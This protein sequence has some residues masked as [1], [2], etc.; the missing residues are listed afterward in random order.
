MATTEY[1]TA[2]AERVQLWAKKIWLEMPREIFWGKFMK[3][4]DLNSPIEVKRDLEG[5]PG[6]RL[7]FYLAN[8]LDGAGVAGDNILED[9][10]EQL[11]TN[12]D[13]V[14]LDQRRNAVRLKG[15]LSEKRTAFDQRAVAK[16]Q[17]KTWL[18]EVIDDD[19]FSQF[20]TAPSTTI[21]GGNVASLALL[22]AGGVITPALMDRLVA[23]SAKADPKIWPV[24]INGEDYFVLVIHTDVAFDLERDSEWNQTIRDAG[25]RGDQN[26]IFTGRY[27]MYRGTVIHAHEKVPVGTDAGAGGNVAYASNMFLGRQAGCF[28]WGKRPEAWEKEF[29]YGNSIGFAIGAIW[30]F[31]KAVFNGTDHAYIALRTARTNV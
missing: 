2:S 21:F 3:E 29:D 16:S 25:V 22:T 28:A 8:K 7:T 12:T 18:A 13:D 10:E 19:L 27:G 15:Q 17:L 11:V 6:D 20:D 4:N 1:T 9:N 31:T 5:N 30:G 23:K 14:T 24:K 26:K